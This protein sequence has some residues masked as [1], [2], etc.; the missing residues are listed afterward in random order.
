MDPPRY[1][2]TLPDGLATGQY[3]TRGE[4]HGLKT[5]KWLWFQGAMRDGKREGFW[6][7]FLGPRLWRVG[8]YVDGEKHGTWW[9]WHSDGKKKAQ[10]TYIHGNL[11]N[12][13]Q[14]WSLNLCESASF[15]RGYIIGRWEPW[16]RIKWTYS[17]TL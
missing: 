1:W 5:P 3:C 6:M 14:R 4:E 9:K 2:E 8:V 17:G 15:D 10:C 7:F 16:E 12:S 11:H 13:Y